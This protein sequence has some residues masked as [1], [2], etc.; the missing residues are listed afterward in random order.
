MA[1]KK[2][3]EIQINGID[4]SV[5][6]VKTLA[7]ELEKVSSASKKTKNIKVG[8]DKNSEKE[9]KTLRE[10]VE[11]VIREIEEANQSKITVQVGDSEKEFNNL[12]QAAKELGKE[13]QLLYTQGQQ[14]TEAYRQLAEAYSEVRANISATTTELERIA[15]PSAQLVDTISV[16]QGMTAAASVGMGM[17][18]LF[19]IDSKEIDETIKTMT[20]LIAVMQG[21]NAMQEAMEK[22]NAFGKLL[23]AWNK[24]MDKFL[25]NI[26]KGKVAVQELNTQLSGTQAAGAQASAG[27]TALGTGAK[28]ATVG[29][30]LLKAACRTF[31]LF[32]LIEAIM[33]AVEWIGKGVKAL[34]Q[35]ITGA[36]DA[37]TAT[38]NVSNSMKKL[39]DETERFYDAVDH[40]EKMGFITELEALD[41]KIEKTKDNMQDLSVS[42][43]GLQNA[44]NKAKIKPD[45]VSVDAYAEEYQKMRDSV[46]KGE[47][48]YQKKLSELQKKAIAEYVRKWA[49]VD[50]T[51]NE[52]IL[53][54]KEWAE[55]SEVTQ[56][57]LRN[58][59]ELFDGKD[60]IMAYAEAL[61]QCSTQ[62]RTFGNQLDDVAEKQK[63]LAE[64]TKKFKDDLETLTTD[65]TIAA[66]ADGYNKQIAE[67]RNAQEKALKKLEEDRIK[68]NLTV[69]DVER[70]KNSIIAKYARDEYNINKEWGEKNYQVRKQ[71]RDNILYAEKQGYALRLQQLR[72]SQA[73]EINEARKRGILVKEAEASINKKYNKLIEEEEKKHQETLEALRKQ[74]YRRSEDNELK[75]RVRYQEQMT[76]IITNWWEKL[77]EKR[78]GLTL[79]KDGKTTEDLLDMSKEIEKLKEDLSKFKIELKEPIFN[80]KFFDDIKKAVTEVD[81]FGLSLEN[82][83][84]EDFINVSYDALTGVIDGIKYTTEYATEEVKN[85]Y[86]KVLT[87]MEALAKEYSKNGN[88]EIEF[89][90]SGELDA[91][92]RNITNNQLYIYREAKIEMKQLEMEML[93]IT[94][95]YQT[96]FEQREKQIE[97][98]YEDRVEALKKSLENGELLL[99]EYNGLVLLEEKEKNVELLRL[100]EE[101]KMKKEN[102]QK[103]YYNKQRELLNSS[104]ADQIHQF[105][106]LTDFIRKEESKFGQS[107]NAFGIKSY[108]KAAEE[109]K[110]LS[111][112]ISKAILRV[113]VELR[114]LEADDTPDREL[115]QYLQE[116]EDVLYEHFRNL[117]K[118]WTQVFN[119]IVN[120]WK[121][122]ADQ[123]VSQLSSFLSTLSDIMMRN[124]ENQLM[125]VE[126]E[127]EIQEEAYQRAEEA[128][129]AHKDKMNTIEDELGKSRGARREFLIDQLAQ[130]EKAYL[131]DLAAQQ[132]A[133]EEKEK[134]E[135]KQAALEKKRKEQEKKA[136]I[137]QALI[138]T[139]MAVSNALAV[140]PWFVGLALSA[141]A[142]A[143]GMANVASIRSTPVYKDGGLLQGKSHR[144]GGI[145]V[146]GG[147]AEVEGGEYIVNK[148]TT[149][150]NLPLLTY[151]NSQK[152]ELTREDIMDFFSNSSP[153]M[154]VPKSVRKFADGGTL[155]SMNAQELEKITQV[156]QVNQDDRPIVV[157]V[158]DIADAQDE[159]RK[160]QTLAGVI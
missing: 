66:M 111:D 33:L 107:V 150:K 92:F 72:N 19:G 85:F 144:Q 114:Q 14:N 46:I 134:L 20:S 8:V 57:A 149:S 129:E 60:D 98:T 41:Q 97:R 95:D 17:K 75:A 61:A 15:A 131:E 54:F 136:N 78:T 147:T 73:D 49:E 35:W 157:S 112:D 93:Q 138:N 11:T 37:N 39:S 22:Q 23:T 124:I 159:L 140:Q 47:T 123:M 100:E 45:K 13:L 50:K 137:Q 99:E 88:L 84:K 133:A 24:P 32:A 146:L 12:R 67:V 48:K 25:A 108:K 80:D 141:V 59:N 31:W 42:M 40:A 104:I 44:L 30:N 90:V 127:L 89:S 155:P 3:F 156:I 158:V 4:A 70:A 1:R 103:N 79:G 18:N 43:Q 130:Q 105:S 106:Y 64:E 135:K 81:K 65:N 7:E 101:L 117:Q 153:K 143:M 38:I 154:S 132:K 145:K 28:A 56:D 96:E 102:L 115:A 27:M 125:A 110:K 68:H 52:S 71:I 76:Q 77:K 82:L 36:D 51:S 94:K 126:R 139:Y 74:A 122:Y 63:K 16:F 9:M 142:L 151:V 160:V 58:F 113:Q 10:G 116:M 69:E 121:Q 21:F 91:V 5:K 87:D 83:M 118:G 55:A 2:I 26:G 53:K 34:T 128:A 6:S 119:E 120:G 62:L 109:Y 152:K 148:K 86:K 29:V